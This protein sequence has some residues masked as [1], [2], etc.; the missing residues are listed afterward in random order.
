MSARGRASICRA[1]QNQLEIVT[2]LREVPGVSVLVLSQQGRG[3]PDLLVG[4][5]GRCFPMEVKMPGEGPSPAQVEWAEAWRG[6]AP[7]VVHSLRGALSAL[8]IG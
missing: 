6:R 7:V 8:G 1:D 4:F 2:G 5:R 3:C